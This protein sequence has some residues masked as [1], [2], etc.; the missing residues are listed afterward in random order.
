MTRSEIRYALFS[1][2]SKAEGKEEI[3]PLPDGFE[4]GF[5]AQER[6]R[7]FINFG[8]TWD[9]KED[10]PWTIESLDKS[11]LEVWNEELKAVV[12]VITEE[13]IVSAEEYNAAEKLKAKPKKK[14]RK[15]AKKRTRRKGK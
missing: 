9:V 1:L 5:S 12:P 15:K 14:A 4:E 3:P 2:K 10:E 11:H 13:G 7:G 8:V 6:F